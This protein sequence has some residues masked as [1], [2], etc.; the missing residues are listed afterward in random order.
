[1]DDQEDADGDADTNVIAEA[2]LPPRS[3]RV[4]LFENV[5]NQLPKARLRFD[6]G[7]QFDRMCIGECCFV[8]SSLY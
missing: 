8:I 6:S 4:D 5:E 2:V 7:F 3:S 1:M